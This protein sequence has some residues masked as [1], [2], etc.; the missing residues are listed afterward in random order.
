M[1]RQGSISET[2]SWI[3]PRAKCIGFKRVSCFGGFDSARQTC[4]DSCAASGNL[5]NMEYSVLLN[6]FYTSLV[7][8]F[9]EFTNS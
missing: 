7:C 4:N 6:D 8:K 5:F 2:M 3:L 9:W 1:N